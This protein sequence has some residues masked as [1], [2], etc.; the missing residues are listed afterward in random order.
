VI[1]V[2]VMLGRKL[3]RAIERRRRVVGS[4]IWADGGLVD[5]VFRLSCR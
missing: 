1:E 4:C 2:E 3:G 5:R